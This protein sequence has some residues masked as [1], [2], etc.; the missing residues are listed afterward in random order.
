M[1]QLR[2]RPLVAGTSEGTAL[3]AD[4]PLS[5]WGG[6]EPST[7]EIIDVRHHLHGQS[8][9][10]RVL[11]VPFSRGSSTTS[12]VLLETIRA[13]VAP[14]GIVA[15]SVDPMLALGSI[16]AEELY[17]RAVPVVVLDDE[18]YGRLKTGDRIAIHEDGTI[19]R[20]EVA[21]ATV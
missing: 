8:I 20:E 1:E 6:V 18:Q 4:E 21:D 3:V 17:H 7:G 10:G 13:N 16:V 5:F 11:V 2:G 12:T 9:A 15:N 14:A 19:D